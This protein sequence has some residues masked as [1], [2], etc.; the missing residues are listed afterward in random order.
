MDVHAKEW[1]EEQA[2]AFSMIVAPIYKL[3][4]W[5]LLIGKDENGENMHGIPD[6]YQIEKMIDHLAQSFNE[7]DTTAS[8]SGGIRLSLNEDGDYTLAF[9]FEVHKYNRL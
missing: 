5:K 3:L 1:F 6:R 2:T 4:D 8:A 7:G 9:S